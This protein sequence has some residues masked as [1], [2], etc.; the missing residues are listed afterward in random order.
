MCAPNFGLDRV[1]PSSVKTFD[2]ATFPSGKTFFAERSRPFPTVFGMFIKNTVEADIIR[3]VF[4]LI[5]GGIF[6]HAVGAH[7]CV[8]PLFM[9]QGLSL[10]RQNLRFCHLPLWEGFFI[11]RG[12]YYPQGFNGIGLTIP[13]SHLRCDSSLYTREPCYLGRLFCGT[14]KTVPYG[15]KRRL[16]L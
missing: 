3:P 14:V 4:Y 13:Q 11:C 1:Y 7:L 5:R 8:R 2:F 12:E 9:E 16:F 6:Y 15:L 10:F